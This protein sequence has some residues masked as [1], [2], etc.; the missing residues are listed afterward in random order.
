MFPKDFIEIKTGIIKRIPSWVDWSFVIRGALRRLFGTP[1]FI[2]PLS[3]EEALIVELTLDTM[4]V[5]FPSPKELLAWKKA[6]KEAV[7]AAATENAAQAGRVT[8]PPSLPIIESSP[9]PSN[10]PALFPTKKRKADEKPKRKVPAKRKK[11]TKATTS[12]TDAEPRSSKQEDKNVE[13]DL[14]LGTS[15]LQ[16]KRLGVG[17]MRQLLSDVDFDTINEGRIQSHLD[18]FVWDGLNSTLRAMGL[19]YRTTDKVV[20]QKERIKDLQDIYREHGEKLLDIE[21]KFRDVKSNAEGLIDE[22]HSLKQT[23]N[24]G[25]EMMKVMLN[26]FDESQAKIGAL[27]EM[28]KQKDADNSVLIARIVDAYERATLKAR[29]D[30]LKEYKQDLLVDTDIE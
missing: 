18:E 1:L 26:R 28:V 6:E 2:E 20:E 30:L 9:E 27:K 3:D 19:V 16:N 12:E 13:V 23:A 4:K 29:Y 7:K 8:E 14:P 11:A 21:R 25:A 22:L 17:I 10:V 5:D 24:K 15:L